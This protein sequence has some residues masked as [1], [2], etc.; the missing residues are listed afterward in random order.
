MSP[1][2]CWPEQPTFILPLSFPAD[3]SEIKKGNVSCFFSPVHTHFLDD[4]FDKY[5]SWFKILK[6]CA[7]ILRFVPTLR[8][9]V[10]QTIGSNTH[11][12]KL[13][14][15]TKLNNLGLKVQERKQAGHFVFAHIQSQYYDEKI[16]CLSKLVKRASSIL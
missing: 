12:K 4:L 2:S 8:S 10:N 3:D 13:N 1:D 16:K 15:R 6:V 5:L 14:Q 9:L 11:N 7:W